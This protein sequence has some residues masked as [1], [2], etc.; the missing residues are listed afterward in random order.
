MVYLP[1]ISLKTGMNPSLVR[2]FPADGNYTG[3]QK[4]LLAKT[5][6][7]GSKIGYIFLIM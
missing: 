5:R 7:F 6:I 4:L 3:T 2:S 1:R